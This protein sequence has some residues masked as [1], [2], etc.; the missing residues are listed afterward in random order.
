M[1][2]QGPLNGAAQTVWELREETPPKPCRLTTSR[3]DE[4]EDVVCNIITPHR[5][6]PAGRGFEVDAQFE[7]HRLSDLSLF[8]IRYG[9]EL[10]VE[11][12]ESHI[13][14]FVTFVMS[15]TGRGHLRLGQHELPISSTQGLIFRPDLPK[16]LHYGADSETLALIIDREKITD[17]CMK[18]LGRDPDGGLDFDPSVRLEDAVGQR[19]MRLVRYVEAEISNPNSLVHS[20]PAVRK[21]LEQ[22]LMTGLLF[23]PR[24]NLSEA[25]LQP[26]SAAAP[27]YVKRAE[28]FIEHHFAEP[29][30]LADIAS[31]VSVSVRSLQN[32]FHHFRNTTPMAFLRSVRLKYVR[33]RLM[34]A[35]P[36]VSTVTEI[37]MECGFNHMGEFAAAYKQAYGVHPSDTLLR[38]IRCA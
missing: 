24:H 18:I 28:A 10:A 17:F 7:H 3:L 36:T 15:V 2:K 31:H 25:L 1:L 21:Q 19:W 16:K 34:E 27:H 37:A 35:D 33:S 26:Q 8:H 38:K 32:G 11:M 20:V 23:G 14:Q 29:I 4:I 22:M 6:L 12:L 9:R 13:D 5:L 30:S